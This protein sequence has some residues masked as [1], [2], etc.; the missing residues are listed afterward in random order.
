MDEA[1]RAYIY[2]IIVTAIP[3]L[4]LAGVVVDSDTAQ[5]ILNLAAAVLG[6]GGGGL[7]AHNTSTK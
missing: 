2:R 4:V 5:N 6:L 1:T 3:L 7:A